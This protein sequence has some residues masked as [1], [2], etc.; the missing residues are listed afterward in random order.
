VLIGAIQAGLLGTPDMQITGNESYGSL[1]RWYQDRTT[2]IP[3]GARV[4]WVPLWIYRVAM[5]AWA[6][7]IA[8]ALLGWLRWGW[9]SFSAQ[10]VWRARPPKPM[11]SA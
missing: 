4:L 6:L 11:A 3:S 5:L 8:T 7:W 9:A 1:L 10:G 2:E